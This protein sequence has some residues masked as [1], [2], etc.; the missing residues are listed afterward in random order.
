MKKNCFENLE[1]FLVLHYQLLSLNEKW[2]LNA[3]K[4][5]LYADLFFH[6]KAVDWLPTFKHYEQTKII[7]NKYFYTYKKKR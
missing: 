2:L 3:Y 1:R 5:R 7:L 4:F 6:L